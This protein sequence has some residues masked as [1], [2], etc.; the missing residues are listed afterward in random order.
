MQKIGFLVYGDFALQLCDALKVPRPTVSNKNVFVSEHPHHK[1][2]FY[3]KFDDKGRPEERSKQG[4]IT[5][6]VVIIY[7]E[8][9][10]RAPSTQLLEELMD[11]LVLEERV[12]GN[13]VYFGCDM[14][15]FVNHARAPYFDLFDFDQNDP[16]R[17][18]IVMPSDIQDVLNS[19][20]LSTCK[21]RIDRVA[22]SNLWKIIS[23]EP[24]QKKEIWLLLEGKLVRHYFF[25]ECK[26]E[27]IVQCEYA[28]HKLG[29]AKTHFRCLGGCPIILPLFGSRAMLKLFAENAH[30]R[31][32]DVECVVRLGDSENSFDA[33]VAFPKCKTL[34]LGDSGTPSPVSNFVSNFSVFSKICSNFST[35]KHIR[36]V[37]PAE[38]DDR[39]PSVATVLSGCY[40]YI[41]QLKRNLRAEFKMRQRYWAWKK[42]R[43]HFLDE[44]WAMPIVFKSKKD[45]K[46]FVIFYPVETLSCMRE[47]TMLVTL[48]Y[49]AA[50]I[51]NFQVKHYKHVPSVASKVTL[52]VMRNSEMQ[53]LF[54]SS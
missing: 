5:R 29:W 18:Q 14:M 19:H 10:A 48:L 40:Q 38:E 53:K 11:S 36:E 54:T 46:S 42:V 15:Y 26:K 25:K 37:F 45:P 17:Q 28:R 41:L 16:R 23:V 24:Q 39:A 8:S 35:D 4:G 33:E 7:V 9:N 6:Y 30:E 44:V 52:D 34:T 47:L 21:H 32:S 13:D 1:K 43:Q 3:F 49:G 22:L 31:E 12:E 20:I 51:H 27:D 50:C 2:C